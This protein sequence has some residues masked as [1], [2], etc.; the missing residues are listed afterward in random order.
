[1]TS[2]V[3]RPEHYPQHSEKEKKHLLKTRLT[4]DSHCTLTAADLP[5]AQGVH[6][7]E[8]P[9]LVLRLSLQLGESG[10]DD[11]LRNVLVCAGCSMEP[12]PG[13]CGAAADLKSCLKA[14]RSPSASKNLSLLS[15]TPLVTQTVKEGYK[16]LSCL[17]IQ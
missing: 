2:E 15:N 6:K 9:R 5:Q 3:S 11:S 7:P 17:L 12:K 14:A 8:H 13:C 16:S 1:M 10:D 4:L